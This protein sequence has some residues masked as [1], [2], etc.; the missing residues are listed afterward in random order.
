MNKKWKINQNKKS[1]KKIKNKKK[2][3]KT[4]NIFPIQ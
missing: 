2:K 1:N 4:I 3:I